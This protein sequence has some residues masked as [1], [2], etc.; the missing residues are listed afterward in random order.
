MIYGVKSSGNQTERGL[1]QTAELQKT[2]YPNENEVIRNDIY[3][4]DCLSAE[5]SLNQVHGTTD[6]IELLLNKGGFN[7]K[8][9]TYSGSDPPENLSDDG[10]SVKVA[11]MIWYSKLDQMSLNIK[12]QN[13]AKKKRGRKSTLTLGVVPEELSRRDCVGKV[14]EVFDLIGRVTPITTGLKIDL[15]DLTRRKLDWDDKIPDDLKCVWKTNFEMIKEMVNIRFN[16]LFVPGDAVDLNVETIDVA[17]ASCSLN[18]ASIYGRFK[19]KNG[20]YSCQLIFS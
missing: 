18:C 6:N 19:R 16:R 2:T 15:R 13:F 5:N 3:V 8:G 10:Y 9:I 14:A 17:D 12:E 20:E 7:L 11:E 1:R 4:D